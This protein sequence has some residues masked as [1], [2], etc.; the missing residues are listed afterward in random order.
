MLN[1]NLLSCIYQSALL[2]VFFS[3]QKNP[4][5]DKLYTNG[6]YR[7]LRKFTYS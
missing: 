6:I 3:I 5:P 4:L 2:M 7:R 1:L